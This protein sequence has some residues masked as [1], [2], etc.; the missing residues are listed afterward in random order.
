[1]DIF[2]NHHGIYYPHFTDEETEAPQRKVAY[3]N[4]FFVMKGDGRALQG[5]IRLSLC[6][7][8]SPELRESDFVLSKAV[9]LFLPPQRTWKNSWRKRKL[10]G[11]NYNLRRS[12]LR[13]RSRNWRM[14]FWSWMIRTI[15]C[16]K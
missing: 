13:P 3:P 2:L 7:H 16:Q 10:P 8:E 14:I 5:A 4:L 15:N 6:I 1:M 9:I 12:Q 11:R